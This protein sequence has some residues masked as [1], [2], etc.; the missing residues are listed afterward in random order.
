MPKPFVPDDFVAPTEYAADTFRLEVLGPEHNERD[1]QAWMS[2]IDHIRE[3]PGFPDGNWPHEMDLEANL[4]DLVRHADHFVRRV[5]FTYSILDGE[6]VIGCVY[7]YPPDAKDAAVHDADVSSWVRRDRAEL[8]VV[9]WRAL[10]DWLASDWPF[11]N[12][13]YAPRT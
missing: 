10:T 5:G 11:T 3:T 8:D 12:P 6:E 7:I 9:V 4:A 2:S 13:F 1:H